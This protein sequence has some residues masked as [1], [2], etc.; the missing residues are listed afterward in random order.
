MLKILLTINLIAQQ[1]LD[2]A[3]SRTEQ[4]SA[5]MERPE[6]PEKPICLDLRL[7]HK[8]QFIY[9]ISFAGASA[10]AFVISTLSFALLRV[11]DSSESRIVCKTGQLCGNSCI[12]WDKECHLDDDIKL[13]SKTGWIVGTTF[14]TIG[15]GLLIAAFIVPV[16]L[17]VKNRVRCNTLQC[18]LTFHF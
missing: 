18:A 2:R 1:P 10:T 9:T 11:D 5:R 14:G 7:L 6:G 13:V 4:E 12:S 3:P 16:R 8:R 17:E 15:L